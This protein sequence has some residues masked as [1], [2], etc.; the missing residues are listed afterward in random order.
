MASKWLK[1][2]EPCGRKLFSQDEKRFCKGGLDSE[3]SHIEEGGKGVWNRPKRVSDG[4]RYH[5]CWE[6]VLAAAAAGRERQFK[7]LK[8]DNTK[9]IFQMRIISSYTIMLRFIIRDWQMRVWKNL[10]K[11]KFRTAPPS[12]SWS[13]RK[14]L[15]IYQTRFMQNP[16]LYYFCINTCLSLSKVL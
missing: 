15:E 8:D 6:S 16:F 11:C 14:L 3:S 10:D 1:V 13:N 7:I 9:S 12:L 5:N 4:L 2:G